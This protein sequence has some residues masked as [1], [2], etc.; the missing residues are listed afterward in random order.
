M[1]NNDIDTSMISTP[2]DGDN[3]I[4]CNPEFDDDTLHLL[5]NSD[6]INAGTESLTFDDNTYYCPPTD[7]EGDERPYLNTMPDIGVDETPYTYV[8][9]IEN[10]FSNDHSMHAYPN[11]FTT[12]TTIEFE[13][14][15]QAHVS[16]KAFDVLGEEVGIIYDGQLDKGNHLLKW[17]ADRA[18]S[19]IFY[20][21]LLAGNEGSLIKIVK[22]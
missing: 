1:Y 19:G 20:I 4:F 9:I 21:H 2:W 10:D 7:F 16:I 17:N 15:D 13:L 14:T 12:S 6:C 11:P 18:Q 22:L 5:V 8:K 3:N